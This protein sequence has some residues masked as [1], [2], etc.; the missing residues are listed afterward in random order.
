MGIIV[1]R[2]MRLPVT[3]V[4]AMQF[5]SA[6]PY[7]T[8]LDYQPPR[9]ERV[10]SAD[11]A[12]VVR[13]AL[14]GVVDEGTAKRLK[15]ALVRRDGSV[16]AIGARPHGRPIVSTLRPRRAVDLVARRRRSATL[17]FLIGDRYFGT[18]M[19]T[20][21]SPMPRTTSSRARCRPSC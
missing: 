20:C 3:R 19:G 10:L 18:I 21:T 6:T 8:R 2:G 16:V 9:A 13:R 12:D 14:I 11:V 1:N 15:G 5:A 7:E 17:V 4:G